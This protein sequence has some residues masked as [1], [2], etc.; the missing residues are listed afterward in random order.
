M[1]AC[2]NNILS[3]TYYSLYKIASYCFREPLLRAYHYFYETFIQTRLTHIG[4]KMAYS[5]PTAE[6]T[7]PVEDSE[8]LNLMFFNWSCWL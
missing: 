5:I 3:L 1:F 8:S 7:S 4:N 2:N 6:N